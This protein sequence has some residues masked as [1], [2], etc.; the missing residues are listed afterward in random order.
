MAH[1]K[2]LQ[3]RLAKLT[4]FYQSLGK[5]ADADTESGSEA[6]WEPGYSDR[7]AVAVPRSSVSIV[8]NRRSYAEPSSPPPEQE[9]PSESGADLELYRSSL[10]VGEAA[11][12]SGDDM[13]TS[14]SPQLSSNATATAGGGG[15][16]GSGNDSDGGTR[17]KPSTAARA[18]RSPQDPRGPRSPQSPQS[19]QSP[20]SGPEKTFGQF[21]SSAFIDKAGRGS[22]R[23]PT[24]NLLIHLP[25]WPGRPHPPRPRS[26][27]E[28]TR[29]RNTRRRRRRR[30]SGWSGL[31]KTDPLL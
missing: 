12:G 31:R 19:P 23:K 21:R 27:R 29:R 10:Q 24:V 18:P 20:R 25:R 1:R 14:P 3:S 11:R 4:N 13:D 17:R 8:R 6:G 2:N 30:R 22:T 7:E 5:D 16:G 26:K 9:F 15:G 28:M